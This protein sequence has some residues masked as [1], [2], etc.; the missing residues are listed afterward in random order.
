MFGSYLGVLL[1]IEISKPFRSL[2]RLLPIALIGLGVA[3]SC[4]KFQNLTS[5]NFSGLGGSVTSTSV[6]TSQLAA[7]L[8]AVGLNISENTSVYFDMNQM[9]G[10]SLTVAASSSIQKNWIPPLLETPAWADGFLFVPIQNSGATKG[11]VQGTSPYFVYTP[12]S[13]V[14]GQDLITFSVY[15][16]GSTSGAVFYKTIQIGIGTAAPASLTLPVPP[17][18]ISPNP[19]SGM[20]DPTTAPPTALTYGYNAVTLI[21]GVAMTPLLPTNQGGVITSYQLTSATQLPA[22][23][24]LNSQTGVISGTPSTTSAT[25]SYTVTGYNAQQI[26]TTATFTIVINDNPPS[27]LAYP[28]SNSAFI[29]GTTIA[30]LAPTGS[31]G[32]DTVFTVSPALPA[33]LTINPT[34]GILSGTP[35][36]VTA[37]ATYTITATDSGGS[38]TFKIAINVLGA[39]PTSIVFQSVASIYN[40]GST[41]SNAPTVQGCSTAAAFV[42]NCSWSIVAQSGLDLSKVIPGLQYDLYSGKITGQPT[43]Q[44]PDTLFTATVRNIDGSMLST[45][46]YIQVTNPSP[47]NFNYGSNSIDYVKGTLITP[48]DPTPAPT[49]GT[50]AC[51]GVVYSVAPPLPAGLCLC[52]QAGMSTCDA[53][54]NTLAAPAAVSAPTCAVPGE[55]YGNPVTVSGTTVYTINATNSGG[56]GQSSLTI[57]VTDTLIAGLHF[58]SPTPTYTLG[59]SVP[60][61][62]LTNTAG[63]FVSVAVSPTPLPSGLS[64]DPI[65]GTL[66]GIPT[67][68]PTGPLTYTVSATNATQTVTSTTISITIVDQPPSQLAYTSSAPQL[69]VGTLMTPD[70]PSVTGNNV[71]FAASGLPLGLCI[72]RTIGSSYCATPGTIQADA[73]NCK[74]AGT[75]FG[76]PTPLNVATQYSVTNTVTVSAFNTGGTAVANLPVTLISNPPTIVIPSGTPT[77]DAT[78]TTVTDACTTNTS[79]TKVINA[80]P[81]ANIKFAFPSPTPTLDFSG[82]TVSLPMFNGIIDGSQGAAGNTTLTNITVNISENPPLGTPGAGAFTTTYTG[83]PGQQIVTGGLFGVLGG[84]VK[85]LFITNMNLQFSAPTATVIPYVYYIGGLAG[86]AIGNAAVDNVNMTITNFTVSTAG[87]TSVADVAGYYSSG[88][89]HT[90]LTMNIPNGINESNTV[91]QGGTGMAL[92][93]KDAR[94]NPIIC[95]TR[96]LDTPGA[97]GSCVAGGCTTLPSIDFQVPGYDLY[98]YSADLAT[99]VNSSPTTATIDATLQC[100]SGQNG[101]TACSN[102]ASPSVCPYTQ[103]G[104]TYTP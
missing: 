89:T 56:T 27:N 19:P 23:L 32:P 2:S 16:S 64:I 40:V 15:P 53:N 48:N 45:N 60:P 97:G 92:G 84:T 25:Q 99:P 104:A 47:V 85:N 86:M 78:V 13:G 103:M 58:A 9:I 66:S 4:S 76:T 77:P 41:V 54:F 91:A 59:I 43:A 79:F 96:E 46:I 39:N 5:V 102:P 29:V 21:D 35:T 36:T 93:A 26:G 62:T 87:P 30:A 95:M 83:L 81:N 67:G 12:N 20:A 22:G 10:N 82:C 94:G 75:I 7:Q 3:S 42:L 17:G 33:G 88:V 49:C 98:L 8:N 34:T 71:I 69:V 37:L 31:F 100:F 63:A 73:Q 61:N 14:V 65:A 55:I 52:T 11:R 1:G 44:V 57:T 70:V 24:S 28:S 6:S 80:N 68:S 72:C 74:V 90:A 51:V 18:S 101:G 50:S 38:T